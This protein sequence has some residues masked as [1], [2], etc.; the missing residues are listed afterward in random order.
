[1]KR[2]IGLVL[3]LLLGLSVFSGCKKKDIPFEYT[4]EILIDKELPDKSLV[5]AGLF[6]TPVRGVAM[7]ESPDDA[8]FGIVNCEGIRDITE[9]FTYDDGVYIVKTASFDDV[10]KVLEI[11]IEELCEKFNKVQ[12][13]H[14]PSIWEDVVLYHFAVPEDNTFEGKTTEFAGKYVFIE[15]REKEE[16][17]YIQALSSEEY[18]GVNDSVSI[19]SSKEGRIGDRYYLSKGYYDLT[20]HKYKLYTNENEL[21][22]YNGFRF[23]HLE[24]SDGKLFEILKADGRLKEEL[25]ENATICG[26]SYMNNRI[27]IQIIGGDGYYHLENGERIYEGSERISVMLDADT[28]EILYAEKF[29]ST[30]YNL[31]IG[32]SFYYMSDDGILYD[33]YTK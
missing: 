29:H 14:L 13:A 28:Y 22:A 30:S 33:P 6:E 10:C 3:A 5:W 26:I 23:S 12:N 31:A 32:I 1:M 15:Y 21:P 20:K 18:N 7:F 24:N 2:F 8:F 16:E 9:V 17:V 19:K 4:R 27:Y 11:S 25:A